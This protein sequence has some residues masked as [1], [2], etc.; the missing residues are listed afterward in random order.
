MF[1]GIV[2]ETGEVVSF[3]RNEC[4]GTLAITGKITTA[5]VEVGDSLSIGGCCLTVVSQQG[6]CKEEA[7]QSRTD[8]KT[9]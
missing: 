3:D 4:G 8:S 6:S 9:R 7:S 1:T 5:D 2:E